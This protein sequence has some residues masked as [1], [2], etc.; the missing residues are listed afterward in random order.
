MN[1]PIN[2]HQLIKLRASAMPTAFKC[3]GSVQ[4]CEIDVEEVNEPAETGTAFHKCAESLATTGKIDWGNI[5]NVCDDLEGDS[6]EVRMLCSKVS[7]LW[8]QLRDTFPCALTE[9]AVSYAL[10]ALDVAG[11]E[12]TGHIDLISIVGNIVRILDWKTGRI[13]ANYSHQMKAYLS[14]VLLAY[15]TLESGTATIVWV[16]TGDIENYTMTRAQ[17]LAWVAD[18]EQ[19]V[20]NWDGV[21]RTGDH[22]VHCRRKHECKAGNK[23]ARS[24]VAAVNDIDMDSIESQVLTLEPDKFIELYHKARFVSQIAEKV[25]KTVKKQV[26]AKGEVVGSETKLYLDSETRRELVPEKAWPVLEEIGFTE[27]DFAAV[28]KMPIGK[29]EK[30]VAE[31]AGKGNGA[32]AK[33]ALAAKLELAGAIE[34]NE[35][36]KL[37]E[38]RALNNVE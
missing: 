15:P 32:A 28:I 24:Y 31:L 5:D 13:D 27:E 3:G 19:R 26:D 17:A 9:I 18:F 1:A 33:R 10:P 8:P 22:C 2:T 37:E 34:I 16:R 30:R 12:L 36:Y 11:I 25:L 20:V 23:L 14:M 4:P 29:V 35:T 38:R 7:K 21:F 6:E